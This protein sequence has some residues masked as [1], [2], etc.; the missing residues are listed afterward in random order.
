M[1]QQ[2]SIDVD[3]A[4]GVFGVDGSVLA[5]L[6]PAGWVRQALVAA[7]VVSRTRRTSAVLGVYLVLALTLFPEVSV[8]GVFEKLSGVWGRPGAAVP[9]KSSL[10]QRRGSL[11][12]EPLR[13][14]FLRLRGAGAQVPQAQWRG[15]LVCAWDGT[16][17]AAPDVSA[18]VEV[19]GKKGD[20]KAAASPLVRVLVLVA[21][22]S[23]AVIDAVFDAYSVGE[24]ALAERLV[25]S[26]RPGML[27]LADRGFPGYV[28]WCRAA[29]TQAQLCWRVKRNV[30][31]DVHQVLPDGS[32]LA[33]WQPSAT[34]LSAAVRSNLP[35]KML[36][37]V[38][39]GWITVIDE[40][41]VRR[42]ESYRLV[43]TLTDHVQYPAP[44]V[45]HL[46][47]RRWQV[48]VAIK[49][50]K[51]VQGAARLRSR[52][53]DGVRQEVWAWLCTHQLLRI[54]AACAAADASGP[55]PAEVPQIGFTTLVQRL[56][57][58][59][60][61]TGGRG[62]DPDQALHR[63]REATREDVTPIDPRIRVY[64]RVIKYS[65]ARYRTKKPDQHGH[66]VLYEYTIEPAGTPVT[67]TTATEQHHPAKINP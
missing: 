61:R 24:R 44:A 50:L 11:G 33:W 55:G 56:R 64:D 42:S 29:G 43:T 63:L 22:G 62:Q 59:V 52:T 9:S 54:E 14:L 8:P 35:E 19:F 30:R 15:L 1:L 18:V 6:V 36:V 2:S 27:L 49:G 41:G 5:R 26:L 12:A 25:P 23:R 60:I 28:L 67:S 4:V 10:K 37:R 65:V 31:L 17:L 13:L 34:N 7:G 45:L 58:A 66:T 16:L 51:C 32:G 3:R 21:C 20:G 46:Y 40:R 57:D 39:T 38:I 47:G 48:E 53:A